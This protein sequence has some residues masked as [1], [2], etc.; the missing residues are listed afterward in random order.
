MDVKNEKVL[1]SIRPPS[2]LKNPDSIKLYIG[3]RISG[4]I[5]AIHKDSI[6]LKNKRGLHVG[7]IPFSHIST[8]ISLCSTLLSK[9][10][11]SQR[12][13]IVL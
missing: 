11:K 10:Y 6:Y 7:K 9:L 2:S 8:S 12:S 5:S 1:L 3:Q 4:I 13:E